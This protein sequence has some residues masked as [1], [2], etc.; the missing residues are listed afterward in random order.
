MAPTGT[1]DEFEQCWDKLREALHDIHNRNA[2][3]LSFEQL[4]RYS[5]KIVLKKAGDKLYVP[6]LLP[7]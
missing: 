1:V 2:G 6:D 3:N 5:Y 7:L 4:Y